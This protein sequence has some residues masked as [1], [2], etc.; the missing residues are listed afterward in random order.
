MITGASFSKKTAE[1][2]A[3]RTALRTHFAETYKA[4]PLPSD[5]DTQDAE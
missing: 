1:L 4:A 5:A 2:E 3:Y